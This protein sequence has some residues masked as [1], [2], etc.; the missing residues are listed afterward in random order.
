MLSK[1]YK[2]TYLI[3]CLFFFYQNSSYSKNFDE[4]NVDNYFSALI[5]LNENKSFESLKYFNLSKDLKESHPSY[6]ENYAYSLVLSEN[7]NKAINEIKTTKNKSLVDFF[8]AHLLLLLDSIK[9]NQFKK[10]IDHINNLK[11]H[12]DI[13]NYEY[14]VSIFLEEYVA[15]FNNNKIELDFEGQFGKMSLINL[16]LQS[17]YLGRSNTENLFVKPRHEYT[18]ELLRLMPK[19]ESIYN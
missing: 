6:I 7:V 3:F 12:Q 5:S 8:D 9:K 14:I 13:G 4:R 15:I 18:K 19:I 16:T 11:K 2:I 17:C 10:S 1:I